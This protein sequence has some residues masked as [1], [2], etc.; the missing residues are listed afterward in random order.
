MIWQSPTWGGISSLPILVAWIFLSV[1]LDIRA[2][3]FLWLTGNQTGHDILALTTSV[4]GNLYWGGMSG[5]LSIT[6]TS[7]SDLTDWQLS[8]ITSQAD[9]QVWSSTSSVTD[10][11]DGTY[12][13][14][15]AP[16]A[17]GLSIPAGGSVSS[18]RSH[19]TAS[20]LRSSSRASQATAWGRRS[21]R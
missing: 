9:V 12:R 21:R 13:V 10:L 8:F 7:N 4:S 16:P 14:T 1:L 6:N 5:T 18:P 17:W 15:A 11:G 3:C 19:S 2:S 20:M